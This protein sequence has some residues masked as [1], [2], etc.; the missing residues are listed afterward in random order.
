MS[1]N[2]HPNDT[3]AAE[4]KTPVEEP[5]VAE[6][7]RHRRPLHIV[8]RLVRLNLLVVVP[9]I[10]LAIGTY[11]YASTGRYV[12]SDNAYVKSKIIAISSDIDGR[13]VAVHA[14]ENQVV[15]AGDILIELDPEP[16]LIALKEFEARLL[17]IGNE[18]ERQRAEFHQIGAE[19]AEA[20][21][22]V[23]FYQ[24]ELDRQRRLAGAG[25]VAQSRLDETEFRHAAAKRAIRV[26]ESKRTKVLTGLANDPKLSAE[27]YPAY[28][29]TIAERD[30]VSFRLSQTVITAPADGIATR[31]NL[32]P[33][34]WLEEGKPAFGLIAAGDLWIETNLKE[35]QLNHVRVG[36]KVDVRIDAYPDHNW[37]ATLVSISPATGAEFSILPAQNASGNWVKVVQRLPVRLQIEPAPNNPP[38]RAG[39][40]A[41]VE[42]DTK[43][44]RPFLTSARQR[45]GPWLNATLGVDVFALLMPAA[46]D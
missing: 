31:V 7:P 4:T 46:A 37:R 41:T 38:L 2:S 10:L 32:E 44:E 6:T 36:Q 12:S 35:T 16:H 9:L 1:D 39:M 25:H 33:G 18:V 11:W 5:T 43:Q 20:Q 3:S 22:T 29:R 21:E 24:G 26:L 8:R 23:K 30:M 17:A 42:I 28:M 14:A 40:T 15:K 34:E 13:V 27:Q 45:F 19:I